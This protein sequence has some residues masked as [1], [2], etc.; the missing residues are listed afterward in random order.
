MFVSLEGVDGS[1]KSTQAEL[2]AEALGPDT[3]RIREPGGTDAAERI[4]ELL[5]DPALELDAFAELLLFSAAR[6]DLVAQVIRPA[7]EAGRD[8]VADRFADSSIA[9]QGGARGLGTSHVL[10]LTDTV[11][12]GL[13]PDLTILLRIDP[14][15]GLGRAA[16]D[17]RFESEGVELQRAV[18]E[19]YEEI[20][21]TAPDRV[22]AVDATGA[23]DD[24]HGRIMEVVRSRCGTP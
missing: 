10:S 3:L 21:L 18:A 24:V 22:V 16:G 23:V 13:W 9:Y 15:A 1:G 11:L 8:I 4:R 5:A 17:D 2:L 14:E 6:A 12:D 19:A 20:A 7:L